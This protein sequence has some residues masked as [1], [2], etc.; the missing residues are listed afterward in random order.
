[1]AAQYDQLWAMMDAAIECNN[2]GVSLLR[3]GCLVEALETFKGAARLMYP[4]SQCFQTSTSL[5]QTSG[6]GEQRA[7]DPP[8]LEDPQSLFEDKVATMQ[9]AKN[10]L[11]LAQKLEPRSDKQ[12]H[13][14]S[15]VYA[16]PL[17]IEKPVLV[18]TTCTIESAIIVFNMALV[19]RL[20]SS[21]PSLEKAL[22]L[23]EMSFTLAFPLLVDRRAWKISMASLNNVGEIH[24][25][26][27]NYQLSRQY[28]DT[29]Y[30]YIVTLPTEKSEAAVKERH[31][32]LL[33]AL[34]LQ[35]PRVASAA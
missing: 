22:C 14:T 18:P 34:L 30:T 24:H 35:E 27:G 28:L 3:A 29:L 9:R 10:D 16:D 13:E 31:R 5:P 4:V 25:S 33:N 6:S 26:L 15:F 17:L 7:L 20:Y 21:V 1:M 32:L 2:I 12:N 8:S 11:L 23:F 19:Y